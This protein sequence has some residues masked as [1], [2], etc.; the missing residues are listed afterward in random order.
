MYKK[1]ADV[2]ADMGSAERE[3]AVADRLAADFPAAADKESANKDWA[4]IGL[5]ALPAEEHLQGYSRRASAL[6][7]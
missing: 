5:F 4:D 7:S 1:A 6:R 3:A 2:V